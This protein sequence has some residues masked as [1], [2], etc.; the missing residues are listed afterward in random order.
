MPAVQDA[1]R[2]VAGLGRN[3]GARLSVPEADRLCSPGVGHDER[4]PSRTSTAVR[5]LVRGRA[6][7]RLLKRLLLKTRVPWKA[8]RRT[9]PTT[10]FGSTSLSPEP[11]SAAV[12]SRLRARPSASP[13]SWRPSARGLP[14]DHGARE[15][16]RLGELHVG[17]RSIFEAAGFAEVGHPT[18]RRVVMR[19]DFWGGR[20]TSGSRVH[21]GQR[22]WRKSSTRRV[23]NAV[24]PAS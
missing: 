17:S 16:D 1:A 18:L 19:I 23:S 10:A 13:G 9:R 3:G 7:H 14:D 11:G 6:A 12:I 15:G 20:S 4:V 5:R 22:V 8:V 2:G 21:R 24:A